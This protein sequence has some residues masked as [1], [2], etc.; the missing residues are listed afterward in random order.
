MN[1]IRYSFI[2]FTISRFLTYVYDRGKTKYAAGRN[3]TPLVKTLW[4]ESIQTTVWIIRETTAI[5]RV[6][7]QDFQ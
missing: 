7:T 3:Y 2:E 5:F 1:H 4:S 6:Q